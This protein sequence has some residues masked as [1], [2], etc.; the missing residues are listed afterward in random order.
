MSTH[1]VVELHGDGISPE[2]SKSVHTVA[3]A[4][5]CR[6]EFV[7]V[8]LSEPSRTRKGH[9]IYEEAAAL[10]EEHRVGLKYPTATT[11]ESPN[12]VLRDMLDYAVIHR[13]VATIPGIET[14]FK[15]NLDVDVVRIATGGTYEDPGRRVNRETAVSL[16]VI[17]RRPSQL[18]ARFA[19][20]LAERRG[21]HVVSASKYTI[22]K[23]TD[24][25]FE[26]VVAEVAR[27]FPRIPHRK[28]LFDSLLA[29]I[30]MR[31]ERYAVIV[32]PNE[33]GDFLSDAACG[34]IGSIGLGDSSNYSFDQAG[35]VHVAMFDPAGG[36]APDIAGR[37]LCNPSAALLSLANLLAHVGEVDAGTRV[38]SAVMGAIAAGRSTADIGGKLSTTQFTAE[39]VRRAGFDPSRV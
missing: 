39:V 29:G 10:L 36:T 24:G 19:F 23:E 35:N 22:Q 16:R 28:E 5:P 26:E 8:D 17:E 30:V 12:A 11:A 27:E 18:A 21:T 1:R 25:L 4:L 20:R 14:N 2:L 6:V 15:R 3:A 37:D 38:R 32:T 31:P 13:P 34:L 7:S 9:A 33:Y